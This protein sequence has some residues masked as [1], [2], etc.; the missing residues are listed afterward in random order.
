MYEM[1][2][3]ACRGAADLAHILRRNGQ[4]TANAGALVTFGMAGERIDPDGGTREPGASVI[5]V[6]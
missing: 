6:S 1:R 4:R 5:S 2:L 3:G